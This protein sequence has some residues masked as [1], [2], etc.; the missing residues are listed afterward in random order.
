MN[1][2]VNF[3]A[4]FSDAIHR[5]IDHDPKYFVLLLLSG[6]ALASILWLL[7]TFFGRLFYKPY[8][9]SM[10]QHILCGLLAVM[11]TVT[12]PTYIAA[13]YLPPTFAAVIAHW[14]DALASSQAWQNK[15]FTSQYHEIKNMKLEDFS[16]YPAPEQGGE[17]IPAN[18][19]ETRIKLSQ[20]TAEAAIEN[21][22]FNFPLLSIIIGTKPAISANAV[23]EDVSNYFKANPGTSYPHTR[24]I[25]LAVEQIYREL[26]PQIPRIIFITRVLLILFTALCYS[27]CLGWI[28]YAALS[29][30]RIHSAHT[31]PSINS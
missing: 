24:G 11:V 2:I 19:T 8:R 26:E 9:L 30:I 28:A 22:N 3:F 6:L 12:V 21:F 10:G 17:K 27:I 13:V 5:L 14:R 15:Q 7:C 29:Q 31:P 1:Y 25:Q 4:I 16:T 20:M 18:H 23:S